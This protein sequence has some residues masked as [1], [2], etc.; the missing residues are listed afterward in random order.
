M[1]FF[2]FK[3]RTALFFSLRS[4]ILACAAAAFV[5]N[6]ATAFGVDP[7][8]PEAVERA[9]QRATSYILAP[10]DLIDVKVFQEDDLES[11]LRISKDGTITFPLIGSVKVGGKT[12]QDAARVIR[13]GLAKGYLVNPQV[14]VNVL[15]FTKYRVTVLG[16]VQKP[17]SYDF[18][19]RESLGLLEAIGLAGGYT[20]G[21][22]PSKV[23]VKRVEGGKEKVYQLNAKSMAS[24]GTTKGFEVLPGDVITVAESIF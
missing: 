5:V 23:I 18:P 8:K 7:P 4:V 1:C 6:L 22:N 9:D 13:D 11:K 17:G 15:E 10:N 2:K 20:R 21:A 24:Q 19:N 16:Q 3:T 12:P 14:S